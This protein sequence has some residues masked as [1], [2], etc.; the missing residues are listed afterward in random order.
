MI[1][2]GCAVITSPRPG[3]DTLKLTMESLRNA[4]FK[5]P[6][7]CADEHKQLG[8]WGNWRFAASVLVR[9]DIDYVLIVEDDIELSAGLRDYLEFYLPPDGVASLYSAA[10]NDASDSLFGWVAVKVPNRAYGALAYV[11]RRHV[12]AAII[13]DPPF[14]DR[15]HGTDHNIGTW[16]KRQGVPYYVHAPSFA[17]HRGEFSTLPDAGNPDCRQCRRWVESVAIRYDVAAKKSRTIAQVVDVGA[18][19]CGVASITRL[20]T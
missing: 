18:N 7:I 14:P 20:V 5:A 11:M 16:C 13:A 9:H 3:P 10:P 2:W 19:S 17:I 12:A 6:V 15:P 8:A 4:G 1:K